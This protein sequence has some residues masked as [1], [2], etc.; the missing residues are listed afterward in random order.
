MRVH[1]DPFRAIHPGCPHLRRCLAREDQHL[2]LIT[3]A[4]FRRQ[5][6]FAEL[7][8]NPAPCP[9]QRRAAGV[10]VKLRHIQCAFIQQAAVIGRIGDIDQAFGDVLIDMFATLVVTHVHHQ[11]PVLGDGHGGI[12]VL[13]TAQCGVFD[14]R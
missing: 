11:T 5:A 13:E 8:R 14:W 9:L 4:V 7:Q 6:V 1:G 12:F 10:T 3:E 2:R